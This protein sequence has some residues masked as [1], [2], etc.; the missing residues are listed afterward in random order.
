[1]LGPDN[2]VL[3]RG[4]PA[5]ASQA[6]I[7]GHRVYDSS[8]VEALS[9]V[10]RCRDFG[11]TVEQTRDLLGLLGDKGRDCVEARDIAQAQLKVV[12]AKTL[13]LMDL[14]RSLAKFVTSCEAGCIRG[15]APKCAI[16][17]DLGSKTCA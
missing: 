17:T 9:F 6:A 7:S 11:F 1:M 14:E 8:A 10:R 12:R 4:R 2:S 15:P 5:S 13:E 16:L 3:R